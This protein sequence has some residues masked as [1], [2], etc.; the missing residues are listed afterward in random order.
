M[1]TVLVLD[2]QTNQA[3]AC[4]RSLGRA[5]YRV[6]VA[7]H[8]RWPLAAWSRFS[9]RQFH[10]RGET[11]EEYARLRK[12]IA[13]EGV[14]WVLPL[15]ERACI[16]CNLERADWERMGVRVA[17]ASEATLLQAFDKWATINRAMV[18]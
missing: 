5:G 17:S 8:W 7:S 4:A 1:P 14:D 6:M 3:L 15:T 2:G 18:C 11:L 13:K 12:R 10:L 16:L 9:S